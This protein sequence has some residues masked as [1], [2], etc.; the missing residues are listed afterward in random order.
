MV[1][2]AGVTYTVRALINETGKRADPGRGLF[3]DYRERKW[4]I[5]C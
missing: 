2:E 4:G 1:S 3:P 5:K